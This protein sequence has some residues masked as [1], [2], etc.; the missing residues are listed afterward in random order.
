M[1]DVKICGLKNEETLFAAIDGGARYIG[2]NFYPPSPRAVTSDEALTLGKSVPA[3]CLRVGVMVDPDDGLIES[4]APALDAI[5][6]H[7]KETPARVRE[8]KAATGKTIIKAIR[9]KDAADL[10]PLPAFAEVADIILFDAKPPSTPG[11]L[12]GGN[13]LT[14]DWRLLQDLRLD[15]PWILSG[16]LDASNLSDAVRLC[17]APAVDVASGVESAPGVKDEA[18]IRDFLVRAARL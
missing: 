12:P 7:G 11:S 6:L 1:V 8:V 9:V 2:F 14:F 15:I 10:A 5:Q 16:G 17:A 13:G 3:S 4:A 18:K